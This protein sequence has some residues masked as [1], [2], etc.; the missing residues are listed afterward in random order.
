M[1]SCDGI[2]GESVMERTILK[3]WINTGNYRTICEKELWVGLIS[4]LEL[5]LKLPLYPGNNLAGIKLQNAM[6]DWL[7]AKQRQRCIA[8]FLLYTVS[9]VL[10]K[11][12]IVLCKGTV[13][14]CKRT[15]VFCKGS[16]VFCWGTIVLGKE[17]ILFV[18]EL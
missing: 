2:Y 7:L 15:I 6:Q 18:K 9:I 17:T 4:N 11:E 1:W 14:L 3:G 10:C 12:T 16:I 13:V 5:T 8:G